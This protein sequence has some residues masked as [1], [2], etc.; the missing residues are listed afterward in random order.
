MRKRDNTTDTV[1]RTDERTSDGNTYRYELVMRCGD[2]VACWRIPLYSIRVH[3]TLEDGTVT[4]AAVKD[5]FADLGRAVL[6]Y[7][8]MLKNLAT[9]VD[10]AYILEDE[11]TV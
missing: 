2:G 5:V 6:F 10:L 7:E 1:I 11:L 9:P 8:K 3:L 4:N